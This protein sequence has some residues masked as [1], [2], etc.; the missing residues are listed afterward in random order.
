MVDQKRR[1]RLGSAKRYVTG[2]ESAAFL[3]L[4]SLLQDTGNPVV[5]AGGFT[6][7]FIYC[8]LK[9][10]DKEELEVAEEIPEKDDSVFSLSFDLFSQGSKLEAEAVFYRDEVALTPSIK[11][12]TLE[13]LVRSILGDS[14]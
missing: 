12:K 6:L 8:E 9:D 2:H 3:R 4:L 11:T 7:K 1:E 5:V 14:P 13:E 10:E